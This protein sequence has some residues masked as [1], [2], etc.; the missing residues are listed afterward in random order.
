MR[1]LVV[2][3]FRRADHAQV[4]ALW[5][6][7]FPDDPPWNDPA[8]IIERKLRVQ[9]ELFL[10]G[11]A[12]G[13]IVAAAMA[14][15]DGH[16]GWVHHLAVAESERGKGLGSRMMS[17]VERRLAALGCVK[18]NLQVRRQNA[19]VVEFYRRIG[20]AEEDRI[21]MGK[22]LG[23]HAVATTKPRARRASRR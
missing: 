13:R 10:V 21:S 20:F 3:A 7:A 19:R 4:V 12:E 11:E 6:A 14:G 23:P 1:G 2:R 22:R 15:F 16:R 18:L 9:R 17:E 8:A 5:S